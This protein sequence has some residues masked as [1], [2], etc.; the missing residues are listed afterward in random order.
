MKR[1]PHCNRVERDES[2]AFCRVDGTALV[3]DSSSLNSEAGTAQLGSGSTPA[4]VATS[5]LPHATAASMNRSTGPTTVLQPPSVSTGS[6]AKPKRRRTAI[7]VVVVTAMIAA[8]TAVIVN[9]YLSRKSRASIESIAVMPFVNQS[10]NADVEYLS[11]GMTETLI[12]SL[13]QLPN[14]N[15]KPRSSV[16]RYK[17]KETDPQTISKELNVQAILNGRVAQRGQ[18]VSL[19]IEL[20]DVALDKVIWS[21]QYNRKQTDLVT[22][23]ADIARDVSSRLKTK[24]SGAD[25]AK[26]TKTYTTNP[27]A[28]QL[29]LKGNYYY[30]KYNED[31][32]K[33]G[34][35][36]YQ[37]AVALDPNYALAYYGIGA[38]YNTASDWYLPPREAGPKAKA[39]ILRALEI[40]DT[41]PQAHRQ[42]GVLAFWYDWDWIT[43]ERE[44]KRASELDSSYTMYGPYLSAMG[45]VDEAIIMQQKAVQQFPLDLQ[46]NSDLEGAYSWA[47]RFDEAMVQARK[48]LEIDPNYWASYQ[49]MGLVY[50]HK[51]QFPEA[52][53]A[54]EKAR[55]LDNNPSILGYLGYVYAAA[56]K[57]NDALRLVDELKELSKQRHVPPYS[58]AIIYSGLNDKDRAFEWLN[59]AYDERSF[60]ITLI[61]VE[62]VLDN[63]RP[64]LRFKELQK[65]VNLPE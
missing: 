42:L 40:D 60:F 65:R 29:Y 43:A 1:C 33:K 27:E 57:K 54:I 25:E 4:E 31:G 39:A 35:G 15:V 8:I 12:S 41:L 13:S 18:D 45:R 9:S 20:I 17:G 22:L 64:D 36:Y 38:A 7:A 5:M 63:L 55:S 23:Q 61:K 59:K 2:L 49:A 16:F 24:L 53:A 50:A 10:G 52:I 46:F 28:Y 47:R 58:I 3:N 37:K 11:D 56:G 32:F 14:L 19:F 21:Q 48:T 51:K 62:H 30:S 44:M 34:L 26:V 6:L